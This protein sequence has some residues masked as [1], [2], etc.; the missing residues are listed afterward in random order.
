MSGNETASKD[1]FFRQ[2]CSVLGVPA[3]DP[4][5]GDPD[6]PGRRTPFS[7]SSNRADPASPDAQRGAER[8][9]QAHDRHRA[10]DPYSPACRRPLL[11]LRSLR[12]SCKILI[13]NERLYPSSLGG[14]ERRD[15]DLAVELGRR[16]HEVTLLGFGRG[17]CPAPPGVRSVSLGELGRL[18]GASGKRSTF[19]A[20][21]FAWRVAR[22]DLAPY[23]VVE[24]SNIPYVHLLPLALRCALAGKPLLVTWYEFWGPYWSRYLGPL[25][26]PFYRLGEWVAAQLGTAVVATS[27]LTAERLDARRLRAGGVPVVPCGLHDEEIRASAGEADGGAAEVVFAGRLIA[28]KRVDLLLRAVARLHGERPPRLVVFG[29]GP[30][31][32]SLLALAERL[33]ISARVEFRG[34]VEDAAELWSAIGQARV[35]VQPSSREG[36][37][38]FPLEAM[39]LGVP[40]VYCHSED[41]ALPEL[42]RDGVEG[43]AVEAR[44]EPLAA[45]LER[46]LA[47]EPLRAALGAS[48]ARRAGD[49]SWAKVGGEM[50]ALLVAV[51]GEAMADPDG[52]AAAETLP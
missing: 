27:R 30:E 18:Y 34:H 2:R 7:T 36:F 25:R 22:F 40:V 1:T 24:A 45:A 47:D 13:L 16:G 12:V 48:G 19:Q 11:T 43:L 39:V 8:R 10:V 9:P 5:T 51:A 21:S 4:K 49:Y 33:G 15:H 31:R 37:G 32:S 35:A 50:E 20:F 29:D 46:L 41:S 28:E 38:L 23:D 44:A 6:G 42:V 17:P 52:A 3:P 26:A 14:V